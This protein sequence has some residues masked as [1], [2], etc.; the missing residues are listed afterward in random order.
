M[1]YLQSLCQVAY[2]FLVV[3]G[4]CS[5]IINLVQVSYTLVLFLDLTMRDGEKLNITPAPLVVFSSDADEQH[6]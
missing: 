3:V 6:R 1:D 2:G 5:L 4:V